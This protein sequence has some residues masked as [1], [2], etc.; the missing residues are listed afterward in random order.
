M[1]RPS[2]VHESPGWA[3]RA[4]QAQG[5]Q[6]R[7][8]ARDIDGERIRLRFVPADHVRVVQPAQ[9]DEGQHYD[10]RSG[11]TRRAWH[12]RAD[13]HVQCDRRRNRDDAGERGPGQLAPRVMQPDVCRLVSHDSQELIG[14]ELAGDRLREH[15]RRAAEPA[16][17]LTR[18]T[19]SERRVETQNPVEIERRA[20]AEP[21]ERVEQRIRW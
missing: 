20:S 7:A 4:Q 2:I 9:D 5:V 16:H 21:L 6:E 8:R 15:E 10:Q 14:R 19:A 18:T 1:R 17:D 11:E 13:Q 12:E 3:G